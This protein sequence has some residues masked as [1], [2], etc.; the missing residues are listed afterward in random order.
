MA[1]RLPQ[2]VAGNKS[3]GVADFR[4]KKPLTIMAW[5]GFGMF[6]LILTRILL[7]W[8]TVIRP[9]AEFTTEPMP[10]AEFTNRFEDIKLPASATSILY[11][12]S[13]AGLGGRAMLYRF[14][15]P[16]SDCVSYARRLTEITDGQSE[17]AQRG[18][19]TNLVAVLS[20]PPPIQ[21]HL[22][23][24]Y[25]LGDVRWFDCE[26]I[27][28]GFSGRGSPNSLASFWIDTERRRFYYYWTD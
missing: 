2:S 25:G 22:L 20:P 15:A 24:N 16:V 26:N 23:R 1:G 5:I 8:S 6:A 13:S 7:G 18:A 21:K 28:A 14:D 11:A 9:H 12:R 3:V 4:M 17:S 19:A 27:R 10:L